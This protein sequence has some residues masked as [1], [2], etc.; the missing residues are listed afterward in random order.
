MLWLGVNY[1]CNAAI[2]AELEREL[3]TTDLA[4]QCRDLGVPTLIVGGTK[5]I[6]LRWAVDSLRQAL[7]NAQ[8]VGLADAGH[9]PWTEQHE[10]FG[11]VVTT[12]LA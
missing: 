4:G 9:L 6:R 11:R 3:V 7:P 2:N 10:H 8:R 1:D 5:D 12:F